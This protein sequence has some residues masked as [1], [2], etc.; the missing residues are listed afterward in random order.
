MSLTRQK[1]ARE[2][3]PLEHY[4]SSWIVSSMQ[5]TESWKYLCDLVNKD[6]CGVFG[7]ATAGADGSDLGSDIGEYIR[8]VFRRIHV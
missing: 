6:P 5:E 4:V 3:E 1:R 2:R 7:P 8:G